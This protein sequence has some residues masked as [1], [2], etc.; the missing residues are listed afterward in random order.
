M[1]NKLC[2]YTTRLL[3]QSSD[4]GRCI[5]YTRLTVTIAYTQSQ[6]ADNHVPRTS[7][8]RLPLFCFYFRASLSPYAGQLRRTDVLHSAFSPS[9]SPS[10]FDPTV[11]PHAFLHTAITANNDRT[12][13]T[14]VLA[15]KIHSV[16]HLIKLFFP[17]SPLDFCHTCDPPRVFAMAVNTYIPLQ[18]THH[19]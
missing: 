16:M 17:I 2:T 15:P 18:T 5:P 12:R 19:Y 11:P 13:N 8:V 4:K 3:R 14:R 10:P 9:P 7:S 1:F 6:Q